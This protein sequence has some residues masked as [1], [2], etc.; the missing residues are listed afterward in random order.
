MNE[1]QITLW[2]ALAAAG[3]LP[4]PSDPPRLRIEPAGR[5]DLGELGP[6]ERRTQSYTFTNASA[7]PI[8]LRLLDLAPGV[9]VAGPAL[10]GPIAPSASARLALRVDPEDWVGPQARNVRLGTDDP[11]QGSYY[12]PVRMTVRPDL[13]VDGVRRDFG[14]V[15][16]F[17]SPVA[18]FSFARETGKALA[19]RVVTPLPGYL[20]AE[21]RTAGPRARLAFTLRP[22]R[23]RPGMRMGLD[24]V[25]VETNAP[26]Q[27]R[28]DL[29]LE[30]RLHHAI[31][32]DPPRLLFPRSGPETLVLRL[33][34]RNGAPFLI[35]GAELEGEGF[36]VGPAARSAAPEQALAIR[37]T[38]T[39]P[40]RAMLTLRCSGE[41]EPLE[42]PIAYLPER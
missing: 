6:L 12:L 2:L 39:A 17:E 1:F 16:A 31:E 8:T 3:P 24:P 37:R 30:W 13:T 22:G 14:D 10:Q 18:V 19:L 20:E 41:P 28:F 25:R 40:A 38:T 11:G 7:A 36:E 27:P 35:L 5:V 15:A 29:Y 21:V 26:L 23:V 9:S 34:S 32:A 42:V 33:K 4:P